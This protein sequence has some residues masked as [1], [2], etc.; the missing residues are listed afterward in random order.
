MVTRLEVEL[1]PLHRLPALA[2]CIRFYLK[3]I[4]IRGLRDSRQII[5]LTNLSAF[6]QSN[7]EISK[8]G[9]PPNQV[10]ILPNILLSYP[11]IG[12]APQHKP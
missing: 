7:I 2:S 11:S 6:Q 3:S 1:Q 12:L 8:V 4:V 5:K 9:Q 10:G